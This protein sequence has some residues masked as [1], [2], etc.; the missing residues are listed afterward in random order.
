MPGVDSV[1]QALYVLF[2][3]L[4][5]G[6]PDEALYARL[7]AGG[8]DDL[9]R[10]QKVDLYSDLL[11]PDDAAAAAA[12]LSAEYQRVVHAVPLR[13]SERDEVAS[14]PVPA[15]AAFL[16]EHGLTFPPEL[17]CDHLSVLLGTM[18]QVDD[19]A[20]F[21]AY[22][23]PWVQPALADLIAVA[24]RAFYKGVAV[25][26]SAFLLTEGADAGMAGME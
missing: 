7:R 2:A 23:A 1:R 26:L 13:A 9:A 15:L 14:D 12:E 20:F 21:E 18:A 10:A 6:P 3:R 17:P 25:M 16:A 11:D 19:A 8:L 4:L 24:D 5:A 22:L